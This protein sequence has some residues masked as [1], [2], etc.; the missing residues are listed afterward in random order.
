MPFFIGIVVIV[1]AVILIPEARTV[2]YYLFL[3]VDFTHSRICVAA[4]VPLAA[5]T[6]IFLDRFLPEPLSGRTL[7]WLVA[8][9]SA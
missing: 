9:A 1:L 8:G 5:L 6:T 4:L 3:R 2:L 7:R